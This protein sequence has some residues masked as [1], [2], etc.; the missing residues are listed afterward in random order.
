M[1]E[2]MTLTSPVWL[3]TT[4]LLPLTTLDVWLVFEPFAFV[5]SFDVL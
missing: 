1:P 2:P 5:P 3:V 4:T